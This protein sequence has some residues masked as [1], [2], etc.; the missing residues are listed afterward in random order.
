MSETG[1]CYIKFSPAFEEFVGKELPR[2][3]APFDPA[4]IQ[5]TETRGG[6]EV[7]AVYIQDGVNV[8]L[9][10]AEAKPEWVGKLRKEKDDANGS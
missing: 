1:Y 2:G 5:V 8:T 3:L 9:W 6:W 4:F 10:K 7:K